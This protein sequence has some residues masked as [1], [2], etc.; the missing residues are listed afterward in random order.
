MNIG[1]LIEMMIEYFGSDT[2]RINHFLKVFALAKTIGEGEGLSTEEQNLLEAA[3]VVHDIG[4]KLSE[5]K[6]NSSSGRYQELEGPAEAKKMLEK[7]D[8]DSKFIDDVCFIVG[9]HHT[10]SSIETLPHRILVEAD[11]IVNLYEEGSDS[12][13]AETA[14]DKIFRTETGKK[15]MKKMYL[16]G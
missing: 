8:C 13:S 10:Y 5:Q 1:K 9:H 16:A 3:A 12:K 2:R 6:Y 7:L 14:Y 4:I 11:L 15:L